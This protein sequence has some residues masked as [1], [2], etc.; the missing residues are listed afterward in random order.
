MID[1]E[2]AVTTLKLISA[3]A[4]KLADDVEKGRLWEGEYS[5]GLAD[6]QKAMRD[7]PSERSA[8]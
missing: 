7:L 4:A 8:R 1:R 6:I 2:Y 5:D 3:R